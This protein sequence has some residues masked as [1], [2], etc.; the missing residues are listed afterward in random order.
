[1]LDSR[2]SEDGFFCRRRR[3]VSALLGFIGTV[4]T[5]RMIPAT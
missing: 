2:G 1:L 3:L 5:E 4:P